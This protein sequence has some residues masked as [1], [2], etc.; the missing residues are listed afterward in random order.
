MLPPRGRSGFVRSEPGYGSRRF[1]AGC[2]GQWGSSEGVCCR[3]CRNHAG[4]GARG[5]DSPQTPIPPPLVRQHDLR[6]VRPPRG[7]GGHHAAE[8]ETCCR[9][10]RPGPQ[11]RPSPLLTAGLTPSASGATRVLPIGSPR[12]PAWSQRSVRSVHT[13]GWGRQRPSHTSPRGLEGAERWGGNRLPFRVGH[14]G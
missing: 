3:L 12:C 8:G 7:H 4:A 14:R 9:P 5:S 1:S 2:L 13:P 11:Q 10:P 6:A